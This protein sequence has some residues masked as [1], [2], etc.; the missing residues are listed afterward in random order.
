[1]RPI[2]IADLNEIAPCTW[3]IPRGFS[4]DMRVNARIYATRRMVEHVLNERAVEQLIN[5]A[6]LP[7]VEEPTLA[8]PDIHQGYGFPIG[9]VV[10]VRAEDG[11]ISPGGVGYDINCGVRLLASGVR[12]SEISNQLAALA[13]QIQRDVPT[14]MGRHG[15]ITLDEQEMDGVLNTGLRWAVKAGHASE[16]DIE[17]VEEDGCFE[18]ASAAAVPER[19][20]IR[21]ADQLGTLGAGNHFLEIQR[22]E[23]IYDSERANAFGLFEGQVTILI[24]TGSRGLGHQTCTEYVRKM[25]QV[26]AGY[27]IS[28]PDRELACAPFHSPEGQAYFRAMA[29]AANFAWCNRQIIT[30]AVREAWRRVLQSSETLTIV[31][32]VS[33][34]I[35]KLEE[36]RGI[37]CLVHRKG[38]TRAFGPGHE[39]LPERYRKTGQPVFI[40][41][42]MGTASYVLAGTETAMRESFGSTCHGAGRQISRRK[43]K[44][45][46]DYNELRRALHDAGIEVRA[47]SAKGLIE[48]APEAYK[49][50]DQVVDVMAETGIA[51]KVARLRPIAII[52]G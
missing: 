34:N 18:A 14:G 45:T 42:S 29:A 13:T 44:E 46:V 1:M 48:E 3:E 27:G 21:G 8:M 15:R 43:A 22:V 40:P 41:G 52:K 7:G 16:S 9:G 4:N 5:T 31:Y 49:A 39:E 35:A 30:H 25:D 23:Q 20:K 6:A 50:V 36:H 2:T 24:H 32:D 37:S 12:H 10:A 11:V 47:G 19:A 17:V 38:A 51:A 33:H 26:M 28:L